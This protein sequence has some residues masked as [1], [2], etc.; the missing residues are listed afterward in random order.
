MDLLNGQIAA[1]FCFFFFF[2]PFLPLTKEDILKQQPSIICSTVCFADDPGYFGLS[3]SWFWHFFNTRDI[4]WYRRILSGVIMKRKRSNC[5]GYPRHWQIKATKL[6]TSIGV[7][8]TANI[9]LS[10]RF[11]KLLF[12]IRQKD[13][14]FLV[15]QLIFTGI[16]IVFGLHSYRVPLLPA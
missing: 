10:A 1:E 6:V 12:A 8:P 13:L 3:V 14:T 7:F 2:S 9:F 15:K 16:S 11:R 5:T 4:A